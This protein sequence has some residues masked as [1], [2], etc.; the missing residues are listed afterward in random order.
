[1]RIGTP[2]SKFVDMLPRPK[3]RKEERKHSLVTL[4]TMWALFYF[5]YY[6]AKGCTKIIQKF[7]RI[8]YLK[9]KILKNI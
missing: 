2:I 3:V 9:W 4:Y 7:Q 8:K 5:S 1:M 6:T